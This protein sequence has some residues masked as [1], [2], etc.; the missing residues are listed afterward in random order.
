[1]VLF[2]MHNKTLVPYLEAINRI[3][4]SL[5]TRAKLVTASRI[6]ADTEPMHETR[7]E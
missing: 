5:M 4:F 2:G 3:V 6:L 1:M 7:V